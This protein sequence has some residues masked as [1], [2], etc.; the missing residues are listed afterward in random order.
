M[1]KNIKIKLD[2][3]ESGFN[4]YAE[5]AIELVKALKAELKNQIKENARLNKELDALIAQ[6]NK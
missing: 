4:R 2:A 3:L 6:K 1:D 5:H